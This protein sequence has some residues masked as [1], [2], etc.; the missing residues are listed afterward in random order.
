[1]NEKKDP[2]FLLKMGLTEE[3]A[4]TIVKEN[5]IYTNSVK[6]YTYIEENEL[7]KGVLDEREGLLLNCIHKF[8][9]DPIFCLYS[10]NDCD[11]VKIEDETYISINKQFYINFSKNKEWCV[12]IK[13]KPFIDKCIQNFKGV[14]YRLGPVLYGFLNYYQQSSLIV[15]KNRDSIYI[16]RPEFAYQNEYRLYIQDSFDETYY[17]RETKKLYYK[18]KTEY[19]GKKYKIDDLGTISNKI[20]LDKNNVIV[21]KNNVLINITEIKYV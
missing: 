11:I 8:S 12:V 4:D 1:M 21:N 18:D 17:N 7:N 2:I 19:K 13:G 10:I 14:G 3:F 6:Y 5:K 15:D 9:D 16:K 20:K